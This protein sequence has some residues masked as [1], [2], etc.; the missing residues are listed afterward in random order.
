MGALAPEV[1]S[2]LAALPKALLRPGRTRPRC[3]QQSRHLSGQQHRSS[4]PVLS[5]PTF[6]SKDGPEHQ[7]SFHRCFDSIVAHSSA[8]ASFNAFPDEPVSEPSK[9]IDAEEVG[10]RLT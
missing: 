10:G 3:R 2:P 4:T 9:G 6:F 5:V 8:A 1:A 7:I